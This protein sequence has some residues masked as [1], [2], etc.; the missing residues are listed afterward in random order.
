MNVFIWYAG[1]PGPKGPAGPPGPPGQTVSCCLASLFRTV[2]LIAVQIYLCHF[3]FLFW[4]KTGETWSSWNT[5]P[6]GAKGGTW[7]ESE[8]TQSLVIFSSLFQSTCLNKTLWDMSLVF[9]GP[10][11]YPGER[12]FRG[13]PVSHLHTG[14]LRIVAWVNEHIEGNINTCHS[15]LCYS[16]LH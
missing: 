14:A 15:W 7:R 8:Y 1:P 11:G 13:E 9:Q 6:C 10:L 2:W 16:K 3:E 5:G 4:L 12:G